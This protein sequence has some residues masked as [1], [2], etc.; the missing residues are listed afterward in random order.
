MKQA[1][2]TINIQQI[3]PL[4][5]DVHDRIFFEKFLEG[6]G[7]PKEAEIRLHKYTSFGGAIHGMD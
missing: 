1:P 6:T 3:L 4:V 2:I 5:K 7:H